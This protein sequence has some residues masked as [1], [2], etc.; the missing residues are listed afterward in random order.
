MQGRVA[1]P[2]QRQFSPKTPTMAGSL[3]L[4]NQTSV[5]KL[6]ELKPS[7][8][9]IQPYEGATR[10]CSSIVI[11]RVRIVRSRRHPDGDLRMRRVGNEFA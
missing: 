2:T 8:R 3:R 5:A 7:I 10:T 6:C 9:S 4:E 1:Q 11:H